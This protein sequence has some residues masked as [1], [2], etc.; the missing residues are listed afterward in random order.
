MNLGRKLLII[1][2]VIVG[3]AYTPILFSILGYPLQDQQDS[4]TISIVAAEYVLPI[5]IS[6]YGG[7]SLLVAGATYRFWKRK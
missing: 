7:Y 2:L 5:Q 4:G 3:L 6:T 1:G